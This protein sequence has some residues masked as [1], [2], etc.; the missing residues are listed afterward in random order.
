MKTTLPAAKAIALAAFL[1][2]SSRADVGVIIYESKGADVRR[3]S[4][5]HIALI[6]TRLCPAGIDHLRLC[7]PGETP[8]AVLTRYANVAAGYENSLLVIPIKDHFTATRDAALVPAL[9]SGGTLEAMQMEYWDHYLRPY[10]PPLSQARY[11][12]MRAELEAFDAGRTFRR[13]ITMDYLITLL[14]P[15][16]KKYPTEPIAIIHP[17]TK[18]LIPNGR[19]RESVGIQHMRSSIVV[20]AA[21]TLEQEQRLIELT[22]AAGSQ[23]FN[24][25]TNNCS[26]FIARGLTAVFGDTGFQTRPRPLHVADAWITTPLSV[27]TDFVAF[28]KRTKV[29]LDVLFVPM[30]AGTRRPSVCI[31][32]ISRG[33]L[34]PDASQGKMAF[35]MKVYFN[36]LNPILGLASLGADK[37]SFFVN[38]PKL[39]HERGTQEL[40]RLSNTQPRNSTEHRREQMAVFGTPSCWKAK[41]DQFSRFAAYAAEA[42]LLSPV[43]RKFLLKIGEP[44]LLPRFYEQRAA[45]RGSEG[46]LMAGVPNCVPGDCGG[47]L[48]EHLMPPMRKAA[49]APDGA[50]AGLVPGRPEIRAMA[51]A[52]D[53]ETQRVAFQL[54]TAVVNYDLSSLPAKRRAAPE[55][56][57]DWNLFL[58]VGRKNGI[59]P[60]AGDRTS[61]AVQ[62]CSCREFDAGISKVDAFELD[63]SLFHRFTGELRDLLNG[64]NR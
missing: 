27:A 53:R 35:S 54:I 23:P 2:F 51:D 46:I 47:K 55:F 41:Q 45:A 37:A 1:A 50:L 39:V 33:A 56:D 32:S 49:T 48:A 38:L 21:T 30:Q 64:P 14:G 10:F 22:G 9:S 43:E 36:F 19:W 34:V 42:G 57:S 58:E 28:A 20:T 25:L 31:T 8:G 29:P 3:T 62:A 61:E 18:E 26:D 15:H 16:K 40:S 17:G 24:A 60:A 13:A 12:E 63:R 5:G 7:G 52:A 4:T 11:E 44:Y 6:S 59:R